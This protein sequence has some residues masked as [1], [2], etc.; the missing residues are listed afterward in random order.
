MSEMAAANLFFL[1]VT[2]R[3][4]SRLVADGELKGGDLLTVSFNIHLHIIIIDR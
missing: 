4:G 2:H 3:Y 1:Y